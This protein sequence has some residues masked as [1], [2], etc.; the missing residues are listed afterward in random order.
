MQLGLPLVETCIKSRGLTA[1]NLFYVQLCRTSFNLPPRSLISTR[2]YNNEQT[3]AVHTG[4]PSLGKHGAGNGLHGKFLR[5][6]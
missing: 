1:V 4:F 6:C 3:S 5:Y 2:D